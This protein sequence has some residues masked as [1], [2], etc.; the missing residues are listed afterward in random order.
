MDEVV[1]DRLPPPYAK[2]KTPPPRAVEN[3]LVGE[4]VLAGVRTPCPRPRRGGLQNCEHPRHPNVAYCFYFLY[5]LFSSFVGRGWGCWCTVACCAP[6]VHLGPGWEKDSS[7]TFFSRVVSGVEFYISFTIPKH[8][9]SLFTSFRHRRG[10][11][12]WC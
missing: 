12:Y 8:F 10:W 7:F 9:H 2:L 11:G 4:V 3:F 6:E 1:S 5:F